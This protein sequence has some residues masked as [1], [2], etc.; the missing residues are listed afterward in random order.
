M[1]YII[2]IGQ[3]LLYYWAEN[4]LDAVSLGMRGKHFDSSHTCAHHWGYKNHCEI[5][6]VYFRLGCNSLFYTSIIDGWVYEF[7]EDME[8]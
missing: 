1:C 2:V 5:D 8:I 4:E 3:Q 7:W 6:V